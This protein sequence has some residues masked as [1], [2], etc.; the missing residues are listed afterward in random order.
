M[1]QYIEL[2]GTLA[3]VVVAISLM[4]KNIKWL[5]ILNMVGA[6]AF[7]A[8][9]VLIAAVPVWLLNAFIVGIDLYYLI[10]M[11]LTRDKFEVI[12]RPIDQSAYIELFLKFYKTDIES[13]FPG[14]SIENKK[15]LLADLV[16]RDM[17]P[18]S[19]VIYKENGEHT[20]EILLDYA[21]P[22]YRDFKNAEFYFNAVKKRIVDKGVHTFFARAYTKPHAKYLAKLGFVHD[23]TEAGCEL[24]KLTISA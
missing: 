19:L 17:N 24:Y 14:F 6:A 4:M 20:T 9:G 12:E 11:H 3:S 18:V 2:F 15:D 7:T 21:V 13:F 10:K 22:H 1:Q 16:L 23:K 8:Y 5:R